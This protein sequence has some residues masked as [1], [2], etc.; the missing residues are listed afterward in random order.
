MPI[1]TYRAIYLP[2]FYDRE[3]LLRTSLLTLVMTQVRQNMYIGV[4]N[5]YLFFVLHNL[6][7]IA[8]DSPRS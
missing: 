8:D 1:H 3:G 2:S 6:S 7:Y 4:N 5:F